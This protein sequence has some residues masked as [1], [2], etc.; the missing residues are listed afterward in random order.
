MMSTANYV[1][2]DSK[3]YAI[4]VIQHRETICT[5]EMFQVVDAHATQGQK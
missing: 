1:F 4:K 5:L 2:N 3:H